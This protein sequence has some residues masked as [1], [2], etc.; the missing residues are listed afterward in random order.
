M[1]AYDN[2]TDAL[3]T[4]GMKVTE[5]SNGAR[6]QCPSH[7]SR[8]LSLAVREN[9]RNPDGPLHV[10]CFAGCETEAVLAELGLGLRDLYDSS[11][12]VHRRGQ[13]RPRRKPS[14]WDALGDPDHFASRCL[15]QEKLE[16]SPEYQQHLRDLAE[17]AKP[18]PGD[19]IGRSGVA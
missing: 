13:S 2:I 14:P 3:R 18:R 9:P 11:R 17:W 12:T 15:Q 6:S 19:Y 7:G 1:S 8:G 5:S 4:A 16:A 10:T